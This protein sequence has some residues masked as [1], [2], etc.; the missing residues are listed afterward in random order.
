MA[1]RIIGGE[2]RSRLLKTPSGRNTRPTRAMVREAVFNMLQG[3]CQAARVLDL[4]S[5]SGA[6]GFEALSRGAASAVFCD[7]DREAAETV[8][9]NAELLNASDRSLILHTAWQAALKG[10]A[11]AGRRFDLIFLDPPYGLKPD[12][13]LE[14]VAELDLLD[15]DGRIVLEHA[16]AVHPLIP[17]AFSLF[18]YRTYGVTALSILSKGEGQI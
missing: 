2:Y 16:A 3:A 8:K 17:D 11:E 18:R 14:R 1:L 6:M 15:A 9:A 5:G 13:V 4:F 7:A 10:L 12:E